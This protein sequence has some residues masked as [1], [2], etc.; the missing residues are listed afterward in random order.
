MGESNE[1]DPKVVAYRLGKVEEQ[2]HDVSV[3]LR[4][5]PELLEQRFVMKTLLEAEQK[6]FNTRL[7]TLE[8]ESKMRRKERRAFLYSSIGI[9]ATSGATLAASFIH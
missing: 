6:A 7:V 9:L 5:L 1:D 2:L 8:N 4:D 3:A